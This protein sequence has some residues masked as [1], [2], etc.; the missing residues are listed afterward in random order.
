MNAIAI[1]AN[2]PLGLLGG[3]FPLKGART[4]PAFVNLFN[5]F[6]NVGT[7]AAK[8]TKA[9]AASQQIADAMIRSMLGSQ[10]SAPAASILTAAPAQSILPP[11]MSSTTT[12]VESSLNGVPQ[13]DAADAATAGDS[14]MRSMLGLP[15][16]VVGTPAKD[17]SEGER[18][19]A[20]TTET[21]DD[22]AVPSTL[23]LS[24]VA[25]N[26][27][28]PILPGLDN[29]PAPVASQALRGS[30]Q[31]TQSAPRSQ[32]RPASAQPQPAPVAGAILA[33]VVQTAPVTPQTPEQKPVAV[34]VPTPAAHTQNIATV[35]A[36]QIG[37]LPAATQPID[38]SETVERATEPAN[39]SDIAAPLAFSLN[40]A[41]VPQQTSA[42]A[43]VPSP[44]PGMPTADSHPV[45]SPPKSVEPQPSTTETEKTRTAATEKNENGSTAGRDDRS[46]ERD[47]Q[48]NLKNSTGPTAV[49]IS[50]A[51]SGWSMNTAPMVAETRTE[52]P[53]GPTVEAAAR[54]ANAAPQLAEIAVPVATKATGVAQ[55]IAVRIS[56]PDSP[57][58]DLH[59]TERG[60]EIHVAVRTPDAELQTSL[61]QDLGTLTNSLERAGYH[62][63]AFVPRAASSS[64]SNLRGEQQPQ[65]GSSG[66]GGSNGESGSEK[67]K[68]REQRGA[69]WLEELEQSK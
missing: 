17:M 15:A 65:Q 2:D 58:V 29:P 51:K 21:G 4:A 54:P 60:G 46:P 16:P 18:S 62:T 10:V 25:D 64:Q 30:Q 33:T 47:A 57:V 45:A 24:T 40:L 41:P 44:Q 8:V 22:P 59:V 11:Q 38:D 12:Q 19:E 42:T 55:E 39:K 6:E 3:V 52:A 35:R 13:S 27:E 43:E 50:D 53:A 7:P 37:A 23:V 49:N 68:Q 56:Q 26:S 32:A 61:R 36:A 48:D 69:S 66:R 31:K 67:Q 34:A 5:G 1:S 63:E 9:T 20:T 14:L 28:A